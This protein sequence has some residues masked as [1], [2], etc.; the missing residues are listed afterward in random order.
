MPHLK[1]GAIRDFLNI[2]QAHNYY[3]DDR[4]NRS[5]YTY[6]FETGSIIEFFSADQP[7]KVRGPRR[8]RLF[9]NE[10]NA[11]PYERFDQMEIRTNEFIIADWN[12]TIEFWFN[13]EIEG[14]RDD[15]E[16]IILTYKDNEALDERIVK[17]IEAHRH[18]EN[19]WRVY[20]MGLLGELEGKIYKDWA[21]IEEIPHEA[22]LERYG[23]DFGYSE[24]PT[25]II[26]VYKYNGG[27]ILDEIAYQKG[28]SNKQIADVL[29]EQTRALVIADSAEPKSI[30]ELKLHGIT[31]LPAKKGPDSVRHGI[32]LL[33]DQ[34][35]SMTKRSVNLIKEYRNYM[36]QTDK[37]GR[38][39]TVPEP[40]WDHGMDASRYAITSIA[41]PIEIP[42]YQP[43]PEPI[44]YSD[45][46]I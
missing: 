35:I 13:T 42:R 29:R 7:S 21:I 26:A 38:I 8:D 24:D 31:V 9:V 1:K 33:Q 44:L 18:N 12:P 11:I 30:D 39:L 34:R 28:L 43:E 27:F 15:Y 25:A 3:V 32:K 20:G 6:T 23:V 19:W 37:D 46:G 45:I 17:S 40:I 14:K 22:R 16:H 4:W 10:C 36:W 2:M 41:T 5:D